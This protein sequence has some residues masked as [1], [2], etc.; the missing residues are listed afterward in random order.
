[1]KIPVVIMFY[2]AGKSGSDT[3]HREKCHVDFGDEAL[4][5]SK[6]KLQEEVE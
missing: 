6:K 5:W 4:L 3:T 2:T 1:M